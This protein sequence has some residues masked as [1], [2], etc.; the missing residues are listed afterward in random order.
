[1]TYLIRIKERYSEFT[2]ADKKIADYVLNNPNKIIETKSQQLATLTSTSQSAI[3]RFVQ[4]LGYK[5]YT[6]LKVDIAK[7]LE[8]EEVIKSEV[9]ADNDSVSDIVNKSKVNVLASIEKTYA[10]IDE[11]T[12][13]CAIKSLLEAKT[14]YLAGVGSSGLVCE[15]LIYKLLR[16][17]KRAFYERDPHTNL[18]LLTNIEKGDLLICISYSGLTKEILVAADYASKTGAK[19]VTITKKA[20]GKLSNLS[21]Y[22]IPIPEI[23]KKIRY[24]AIS[25]RFS[26]QII[27]DILF[28]GYIAENMEHVIG[29]LKVSKE[30]TDKLKQ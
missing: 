19:V 23:E 27:T 12:L 17:G 13:A 20:K 14:V 24:A 6:D 18:T 11:N 21:D 9:I 22:V 2:Q 5:G 15:D 4:K 16:A 3:I 1:M 8:N 30:L 7:S 26:S 28:Y 10:L 29:N 25:S